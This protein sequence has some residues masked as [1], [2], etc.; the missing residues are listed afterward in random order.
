MR[1][2][3]ALK[4]K[5]KPSAAQASSGRGDIQGQTPSNEAVRRGARLSIEIGETA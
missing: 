4:P 3:V 2:A 1:R 5:K